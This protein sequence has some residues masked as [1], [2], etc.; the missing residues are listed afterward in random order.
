[1]TH[2][3][4]L[5]VEQGTVRVTIDGETYDLAAGDAFNFMGDAPHRFDNVGAEEARYIC[6]GHGHR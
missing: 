6:V 5:L 1:M 3:H 2:D 4:Y